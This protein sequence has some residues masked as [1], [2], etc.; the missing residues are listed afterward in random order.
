[1][2][3]IYHF[4]GRNQLF[5][6]E[7]F[8]PPFKRQTRQRRKDILITLD[9]TEAAFQRPQ[10]NQILRL[11]AVALFGTVEDLLVIAHLNAGFGYFFRG[12]DPVKVIVEQDFLLGLVLIG[13]HHMIHIMHGRKSLINRGVADALLAGFTLEFFDKLRKAFRLGGNGRLLRRSGGR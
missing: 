8:A 1:V 10:G 9:F 4:Q 13:F 7:C 6:E 2:P 12:D 5:G 11:D 3:L